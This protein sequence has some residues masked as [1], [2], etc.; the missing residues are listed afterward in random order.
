MRGGGQRAI[1]WLGLTGVCVLAMLALG[2]RYATRAIEFRDVHHACLN[3]VASARGGRVVLSL[4]T[5][6][7]VGDGQVTVS[8]VGPPVPVVGVD[9]AWR[10]GDVVSV[11]GRCQA[12]SAD[13]GARVVASRFQRH[14]LRPAKAGLSV[15]GMVFAIAYVLRAFWAGRRRG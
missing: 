8:K 5:V 1:C 6:T 2:H 10:V 15:V 14:P 11:D 9:E 3:G 13:S 12:A 4:W 7:A